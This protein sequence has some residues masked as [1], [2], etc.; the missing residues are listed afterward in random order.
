MNERK[1]KNQ[2]KFYL[3]DEELNILNAK[4]KKI[5][6]TRSKFLR[7]CIKTNEI[8]LDQFNKNISDLIR[9]Y[10]ALGN[11]INQITRL[12]HQGIFKIEAMEL[13]EFTKELD[14]LWQSLRQLKGEKV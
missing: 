11:N 8:D 13:K 6:I 9:Q 3:S 4:V 7:E 1:R 12:A 14:K 5:N 10:K 2:I